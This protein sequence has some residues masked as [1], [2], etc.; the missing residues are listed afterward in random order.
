MNHDYDPDKKEF[1]ICDEIGRLF[2]TDPDK[3]QSAKKLRRLIGEEPGCSLYNDGSQ[4]DASGFLMVLL[5]L[6]SKEIKKVTNQNSSYMERLNSKQKISRKFISSEDGSCP[7]C[8]APIPVK[9]ET[10]SI[11]PL[12]TGN[13]RDVKKICDLFEE[14]YVDSPPFRRRCEE[15]Q[16]KNIDEKQKHFAKTEKFISHFSETLII[17]VARFDPH[18]QQLSRK[19]WPEKL[20]ETSDGGIYELISIINHDGSNLDSGHF[21]TYSEQNDES[22]REFNYTKSCHWDKK[23][24]I[25]DSNY[26]YIYQK[27]NKPDDTLEAQS[28][29]EALPYDLN[30]CKECGN[31]FKNLKNHLTRAGVCGR[32]HDFKKLD[33]EIELSRRKKKAE[34]NRRMRANQSKDEKKMRTQKE[35][36]ARKDARAQL[37]GDKKMLIKQL[38]TSARKDVRAQ[39]PEEKKMLIT[40]IDTSAREDAR[41]HLPEEV[42]V[43][44]TQ[45]NTSAR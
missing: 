39:L 41:A 19:L 31:P 27:K 16:G 26:I 43:L 12:S 40:Q 4:Q 3:V 15:C 23:S 18:M 10:I 9:E 11:L 14:N 38:D 32:K 21:Y 33:K 22:W 37:P 17:Q 34:N 44:I 36:K 7:N 25:S 45:L 30:I 35:T 5:D 28:A 1:P 24:I 6:I 42:K 29:S 20:L 2:R 8:G 13:N